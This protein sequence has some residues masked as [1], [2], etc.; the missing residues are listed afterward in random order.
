MSE[1]DALMG[2][3]EKLMDENKFLGGEICNEHLLG[4]DNGIAQ[5]HYFLRVP[6]NHPGYDIM[7]M[8]VNR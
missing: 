6:L 8:L 3:S 2:D 7:K 1:K 5:C 4:Y